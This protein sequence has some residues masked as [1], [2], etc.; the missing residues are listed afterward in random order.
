MN[1]A[2]VEDHKI[3]AE[4]LNRALK[5]HPLINEIRLYEGG[6]S[7]LDSAHEWNPDLV[8][9]DLLMPG[10]EGADLIKKYRSELGENIKI[11]VLS[12][13]T[14]K[15]T[16]QQVING[17]ANSYLTKEESIETLIRAIHKVIEGESYVSKSILDLLKGQAENEGPGFHLSPRE[18]DVL[19]LVCSGKIMK[20]VAHELKLSIHTVQSY[21]NNM[22]RK[23]K[24]RRT[25]D[26]IIAAIR[27]G[28]Y[29]P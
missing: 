20:E 28:L 3:L 17:G 7:F 15:K 2:I 13:V 10:I 4:A 14:S 9:S 21:H 8:I 6:R 11:I 18:K 24:V 27:H 16:I 22:M 12:S 23:F 26:L 19:N 25:S 29:H 5:D 1:V